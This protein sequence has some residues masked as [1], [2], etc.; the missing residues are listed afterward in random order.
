[1]R[2]GEWS[3]LDGATS[4]LLPSPGEGKRGSR[5]PPPQGWSSSAESGLS[6]SQ[7]GRLDL[8]ERLKEKF[9]LEELEE[10]DYGAKEMGGTSQLD[11]ID[12]LTSNPLDLQAIYQGNVEEQWRKF[13]AS[14][15]RRRHFSGCFGTRLERIGTQTGLGCH[16]YKAR[17]S[18]LNMLVMGVGV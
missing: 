16:I 5:N 10:P 15:K 12:A 18:P 4:I 1:M 9:Q 6:R 7:K 14:P 13:M 3:L 2:F 11:P 17:R 8:L